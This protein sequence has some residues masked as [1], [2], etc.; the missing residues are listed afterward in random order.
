MED[1]GLSIITNEANKIM[2]CMVIFSRSL[3]ESK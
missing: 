3:K 2:L 1:A